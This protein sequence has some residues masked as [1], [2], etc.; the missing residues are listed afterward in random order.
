METYK[1]KKQKDYKEMS[2]IFNMTN[3]E[4]KLYKKELNGKVDMLSDK[5]N[6]FEA[7]N[8]GL[9]PDSIRATN[10]WIEAKKAFDIAFKELQTFNKWYVKEFRKRG[11][12]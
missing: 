9:V 4:A 5:L 3:E 10:E 1:R 12:A 6:E 2:T 7:S 8:I 11:Q